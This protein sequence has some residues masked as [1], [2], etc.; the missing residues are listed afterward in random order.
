MHDVAQG[1]EVDKGFEHDVAHFVK[2]VYSPGMFKKGGPTASEMGKLGA[3]KTNE[4]LTPETRSVAAKKGWQLRKER[5][6]KEVVG[7]K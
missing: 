3:I 2:G 5:L 4:I 1:L 7:K 6:K